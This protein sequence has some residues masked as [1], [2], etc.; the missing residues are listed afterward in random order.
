ML[1]VFVNTARTIRTITW[2][3]LS[4]RNIL[5]SCISMKNAA[6]TIS[7]ARY[8]SLT[9]THF[10]LKNILPFFCNQPCCRIPIQWNCC[11]KSSRFFTFFLHKRFHFSFPESKW[12][13]FSPI[14]NSIRWFSDRT[15]VFSKKHWYWIEHWCHGLTRRCFARKTKSV[16]SDKSVFG[17]IW[18]STDSYLYSLFQAYHSLQIYLNLSLWKS[19]N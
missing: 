16:K 15:I 7:T 4:L 2:M 19:T 13:S 12:Q 14:W 3:P 5:M 17:K 10:H 8:N 9:I 18:C 6:A 1:R 11:R